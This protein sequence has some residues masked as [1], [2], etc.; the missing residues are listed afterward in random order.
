MIIDRCRSFFAYEMQIQPYLLAL[1][2]RTM[3]TG[4]VV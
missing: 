3:S 4:R 1:D 2:S